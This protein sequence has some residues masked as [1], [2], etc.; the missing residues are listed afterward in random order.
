MCSLSPQ[1]TNIPGNGTTF[2]I[3]YIRLR[4]DLHASLRSLWYKH[5]DADLVYIHFSQQA[6]ATLGLQ[7]VGS[8]QWLFHMRLNTH[9]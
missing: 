5:V 9:S 8:L 7:R 2:P 1:Y 4:I 3:G 6:N